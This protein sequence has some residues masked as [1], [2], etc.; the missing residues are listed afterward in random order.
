MVFHRCIALIITAAALAACGDST[1]PI[2]PPAAIESLSG[3]GQVGVVGG[4]LA[5]PI[6]VR[7]ADSEGRGVDS[8]LVVFSV[9]EGDVAP[10]VGMAGGLGAGGVRLLA[11][12]EDS[13]FTDA[14]GEAQA[15]W[16]LGPTAGE[17]RATASVGG[18]D[19]VE[20]S[21]TAEAG[22]PARLLVAAGDGQLALP[23]GTLSDSLV[24]RV[25]D[26]FYNPLS[27][28]TV[29]WSIGGGGGSLSSNSGQT[30][31]SGET[32]TELTLGDSLGF[33]TVTASF[34][35]LA[36]IDFHALA[37]TT[38]WSDAVGDTFSGGLSTGSVLPDLAGVGVSWSGGSLMIGL[39]FV[40]SVVTRLD[41][42]PNVMNGFVDFDID[43][44]ST[45]G[46]QS[47]ADEYRPGSGSTG[48]GVDV[49]VDMFEDPSGV[50]LIFD[51]KQKILGSAVPDIRGRLVM[52]AVSSAI[53]GSGPMAMAVTPGTPFEPT[54]IAP[55]DSSYVIAAS[56]GPLTPPAVAPAPRRSGGRRPWKPIGHR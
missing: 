53:I 19:P 33:N 24:V 34:T 26:E 51:P 43:M 27:G 42:G 25:V 45:T 5:E 10:V 11:V 17:Q 8:V 39:S 46:I 9:V 13:A 28:L 18:L 14:D 3:D 37:L 23:A 56:G 20:F 52:L 49:I 54:D 40:D 2:G 31:D 38:I 16:T 55:N 22:P 1:A 7:V 36:P 30:D 44:D 12:P 35:G 6:R 29:N 41:G 48:M 4:A 50:Y 47:A 15:T 21:A 32:S